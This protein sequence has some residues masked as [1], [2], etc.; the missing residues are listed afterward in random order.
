MA[1]HGPLKITL[2]V[3]EKQGNR[4]LAAD[5]GPFSSGRRFVLSGLISRGASVSGLIS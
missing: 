4:N 5:P 2:E 1:Q 3:N